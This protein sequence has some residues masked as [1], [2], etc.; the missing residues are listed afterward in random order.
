LYGFLGNDGIRGRDYLGLRWSK[1]GKIKNDARRLWKRTDPEKDTLAQ[2]ADKVKLDPKETDKWVKFE[3]PS[4]C[5]LKE[6]KVRCC[7]SVPN[8]FVVSDLMGYGS[9][10]KHPFLTM[11]DHVVTTGG[12]RIGRLATFTIG[13]K[14][15]NAHSAEE[16]HKALRDNKGDLW[17]FIV[18]AHGDED[19]YIY[20]S[21]TEPSITTERKIYEDLIANGFQ[22]SKIWM[23]PC[24]SGAK[25][26]DKR[27]NDVSY[28]DPKYFYGWNAALIDTGGKGGKD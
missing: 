26:R 17:A 20:P 24:Y 3:D 25:G 9:F 18:W 11:A 23:M 5:G 2:L 13:K 19:G 16:M 7:V 15:V 14:R 22:L 4:L 10:R 1:K 27:W 8:V 12:G 6:D 21:Y 28:R